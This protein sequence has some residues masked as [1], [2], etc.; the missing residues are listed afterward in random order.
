MEVWVVC[1]MLELFFGQA[2]GDASKMAFVIKA[3]HQVGDGGSVQVVFQCP[4]PPPPL[5]S[6][7]EEGIGGEI[8]G[9]SKAGPFGC[10]YQ[11]VELE[12]LWWCEGVNSKVVC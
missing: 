12:Q 8:P 3:V 9:K 11:A 7:L 4:F 6:G 1:Q 2:G 10:S 5:L